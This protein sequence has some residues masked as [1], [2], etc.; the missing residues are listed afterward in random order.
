[1]V[2]LVFSITFHRFRGCLFG[3]QVFFVVIRA[4]CR[5]ALVIS[6]GHCSNAQ[7]SKTTCGT[8]CMVKT[9]A[10][11]LVV[12][13][14]R[15]PPTLWSFSPK[16]SNHLLLL[17]IMIIQYDCVSPIQTNKKKPLLHDETPSENTWKYMK[18][19]KIFWQS[20]IYIAC[21]PCIAC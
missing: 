14:A 19:H 13:V 7:V 17:R 3:C 21:S 6:I 12:T 9:S 11:G 20:F 2:F 16:V 8:R 5:S 15:C 10:F 4:S 1:M 18:I